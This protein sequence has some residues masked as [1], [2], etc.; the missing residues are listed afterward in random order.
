MWV[1]QV[2][3]KFLSLERKPTNIHMSGKPKP[4]CIELVFAGLLV[5]CMK[6]FHASHP[7]SCLLIVFMSSYAFIIHP[8]ASRTNTSMFLR[9]QAS[10]T[11]SGSSFARLGSRSL[12]ARRSCCSSSS[13]REHR[14]FGPLGAR[15]GGSAVVRR[16]EGVLPAQ[17]RCKHG[18][19]QRSRGKEF[20]YFSL[21]SKGQLPDTNWK[22]LFLCCLAI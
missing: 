5:Q 2:L 12:S 4:A 10:R 19:W 16:R 15:G 14:T 6:K 3:G 17:L 20:H 21:R 9:C 11:R 1:P 13:K 18:I 7:F 22:T 8:Y